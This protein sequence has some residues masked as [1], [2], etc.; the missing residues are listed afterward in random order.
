LFAIAHI[1]LCTYLTSDNRHYGAHGLALLNEIRTWCG[2]EKG[3][4]TKKDGFLYTKYIKGKWAFSVAIDGGA[5]CHGECQRWISSF[6]A[7]SL[8]CLFVAGLHSLRTCFGTVLWT[9]CDTIVDVVFNAGMIVLPPAFRSNSLH[10]LL[11]PDIMLSFGRML[12]RV[13]V[14]GLTGSDEAG[15]SAAV[16]F[17]PPPHA[18]AGESSVHGNHC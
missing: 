13:S 1:S 6:A 9:V 14:P 10:M 12:G 8:A 4:V 5:H 15:F 2:V 11:R 7:P 17:A 16:A 18:P 3:A